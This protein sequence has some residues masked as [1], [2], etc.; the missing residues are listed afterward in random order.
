MYKKKERDL[1]PLPFMNEAA[2][3]GH[4]HGPEEVF[5]ILLDKNVFLSLQLRCPV[6]SRKLT[7]DVLCGKGRRKSEFFLG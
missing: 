1:H 3:I 4:P 6:L 5:E 7:V 2:A